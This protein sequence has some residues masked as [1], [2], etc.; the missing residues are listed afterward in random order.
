LEER[1]VLLK[2]LAILISVVITISGDFAFADC[3]SAD[4]NGDCFVDYEDFAVMAAQWLS[5]ERIP[6]DMILIR[7]GTFRMGDNLGDG[8]LDE[9]PVHWVTLDSFC[10]GRCEVTKGQYCDYLN[11]TFGSS[12]YIS[13]GIVYGSGNNQE[14][15]DTSIS[16][17]DSQIAYSRGVFSVLTKNGRG[18]SND[19]M[20]EVSW[21]GAVAYSNWRSE[22]E[23]YE[24]CYDPC[25]P[26]WP[27]D[28]SKKGY[29][30]TTEAEWEYAA[31]GGL[32]GRR[33]P[34][35]DAITHSQANYYACPSCYIYDENPT[36]GYHPG[37]DDVYPFTSPG[38]SFA[39]NNYGLYDMAGN[40][41]EWCNDWYLDTYY[42]S[43][44]PN[45]PTG[46]TNGTYRV[47]R[48]G[49]WSLDAYHCRV[50]SRDL[51]DPANRDYDV[52]FRLVL[53]LQ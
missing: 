30:L 24:K 20:V 37:W 4:L 11:S 23:G 28:F 52:G 29:R 17:S 43:S 31:R 13:G 35:G 50:A 26:N 15:C 10:M 9:L 19:P 3:P 6:E 2:S 12:T 22:E 16:S 53:D 47:L 41:G 36:E 48:G 39:A 27:C 8:W 51:Y 42:S 45:N 21:Y 5:G 1:K 18:M 32:S 25:D 34:W 14:Y 49:Y 38:G 44:P 40:V 46:P 33:F 7:G